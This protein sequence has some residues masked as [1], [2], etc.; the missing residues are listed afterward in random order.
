MV[1]PGRA[2]LYRENGRAIEVPVRMTRD[3]WAISVTSI[4]SWNDRPD[5][6]LDEIERRKVAESVR[7]VVNSQWGDDIEIRE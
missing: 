5:Q 7:A 2:L 1:G 3:S 4:I 6:I